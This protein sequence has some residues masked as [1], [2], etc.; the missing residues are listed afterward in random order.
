MKSSVYYFCI[1]FF[2]LTQ[3]TLSAYAQEKDEKKVNTLCTDCSA[4]KS[5]AC[6]KLEEIVLKHPNTLIRYKAFKCIGNQAVL[7]QVALIETDYYTRREAARKISDQDALIYLFNKATDEEVR[8]IVLKKI[9]DK[10]LLLNAAKNDLSPNIRS[11]IIYGI[12]D[13][14]ILKDVYTTGNKLDRKHLIIKFMSDQAFLKSIV[15]NPIEDNE[16]KFEAIQWI[17]DSQFLTSIALSEKNKALRLE[18]IKALRDKMLINSTVFKGIVLNEQEDI[19]IRELAINNLNDTATITELAINNSNPK[20]SEIALH[21]LEVMGVDIQSALTKGNMQVQVISE[22]VNKADIKSPVTKNLSKKIRIRTDG[23]YYTKIAINSP[24]P[25]FMYFRFYSDA[26]LIATVSDDTPEIADNWLT[27]DAS[28]IIAGKYKTQDS[29][30]FIISLNTETGNEIIKT[31]NLSFQ[32]FTLKSELTQNVEE[33]VF[34]QVAFPKEIITK[35]NISAKTGK[36]RSP[37]IEPV[38][39]RMDSY[40]YDDAGRIIG[41][42]TTIEIKA[43]D[44]DGDKLEYSWKATNGDIINQGTKVTW[45]RLLDMGQPAIGEITVLVTDS[46]GGKV[47]RIF[48]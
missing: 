24:K 46:K 15:N 25:L 3:L 26:S 7:K 27:K 40:R 20:I 23:L 41:I 13:L 12:R 31:G 9:T 8:L 32:G 48:K 43:T 29:A 19:D 28:N 42:T 39:K 2:V 5:S 16:N 22:P 18:A 44:P 4:G 47:S 14:E 34:L 30:V 17:N 6:A 36:N 1:V 10:E 11:S 33:Y 35:K 38:V 21:R 37:V 45:K